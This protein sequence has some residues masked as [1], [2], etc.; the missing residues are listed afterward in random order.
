MARNTE[1]QTSTGQQQQDGQAPD[2]E[3]SRITT[4]ED[5]AARQHATDSKVDTLMSKVDQLL[6]GGHRDEPAGPGQA[7]GQPAG[8]PADHLDEIKRA[9]RDVRAE[10][11]AAD[12]Q[13]A[14][15][16]EHARLRDGQKPPPEQKPRDAMPRG[17]ERLQRL[18]F[19]ADK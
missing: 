6:G 13:A 11:A 7:T 14:H 2:G 4:I 15:D 1:P 18:M 19:G 17:K 5:I 16:A 3:A 9:I 10:D 12:Q 8:Q